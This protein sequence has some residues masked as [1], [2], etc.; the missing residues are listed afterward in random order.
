MSIKLHY[1]KWVIFFKE[2]GFFLGFRK[3]QEKEK[4]EGK[5][6]KEK[7]IKKTKRWFF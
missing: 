1:A 3:M 7:E 5:E 4:E 6:G 2:R